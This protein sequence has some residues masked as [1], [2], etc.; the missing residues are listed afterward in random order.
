[1]FFHFRDILPHFKFVNWWVGEFLASFFDVTNAM[2]KPNR[3]QPNLESTIYLLFKGIVS[4]NWVSCPKIVSSES[5]D[6]SFVP[7]SIHEI[8]RS[9]IWIVEKFFFTNKS[10]LFSK[11]SSKQDLITWWR[12]W[13]FNHSHSSLKKIS[14]KSTRIVES[15]TSSKLEFEVGFVTSK[16]K[17]IRRSL[18]E[19]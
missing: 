2:I 5:D 3:V 19:F 16:R 13:L 7:P 14:G 1:M 9:M 11:F 6:S 17:F 4:I 15:I 12:V 10:R 18:L 8:R